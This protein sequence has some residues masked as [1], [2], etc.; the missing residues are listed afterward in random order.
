MMPRWACTSSGLPKNVWLG[1]IE[2]SC[3]GYS[4]RNDPYVLVG[5]CALMYT[6]DGTVPRW[7]Q[8]SVCFIWASGVICL[9]AWLPVQLPFRLPAYLFCL[10]VALDAWFVQL[11]IFAEPPSTWGGVMIP[12][13]LA[14]MV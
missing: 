3:E 7:A 14:P 8:C 9:S 13:P 4:Y 12:Y 11:E 10:D 6:L 2:V 5:S 1:S